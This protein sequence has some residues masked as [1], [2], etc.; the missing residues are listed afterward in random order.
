MLGN[1][2]MKLLFSHNKEKATKTLQSDQDHGCDATKIHLTM[3]LPLSRV[4]ILNAHQ[5]IAK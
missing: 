4:Y 2:H 5:L 1:L 3:A